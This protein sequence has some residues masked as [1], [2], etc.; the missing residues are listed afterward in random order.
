LT[1]ELSHFLLSGSE[2]LPRDWADFIQ[3]STLHLAF[4]RFGEGLVIAPTTRLTLLPQTLA[5]FYTPEELHQLTASRFQTS[6]KHDFLLLTVPQKTVA[7]FFGSPIAQLEKN[8][9]ILRRWTAREQQFY[10]D[11]LSPPLP[12][13]GHQAWFLAKTLEILSL[14]LFHEPDGTAEFFCT[15]IKDNAH[16]HVSEALLIL[17]ARLAEP[18]NLQELAEDIGCAPHYLSRLVKQHTDK[19]LSLHLRAIRI[20]K[21]SELLAGNK[22]NVTEVALEVG[23]QSLSHFSKA[24]SL[25]EGISPSQFLKRR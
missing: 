17:Q 18:L 25:E 2:A 19:T 12:D 11:I 13:P 6:T 14:H 20:K 23:Y 1:F 5:L 21:A 10:D 7:Q 9:G 3:P 15:K 16:R 4:N 8:L 22:M 24:F